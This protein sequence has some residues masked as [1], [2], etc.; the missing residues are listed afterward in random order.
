MLFPMALITVCCS[1]ALCFISTEDGHGTSEQG[2]HGNDVLLKQHAT[3]ILFVQDP[4]LRHKPRLVTGEELPA[5]I[6][7]D[8]DEVCV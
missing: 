2:G 4:E 8:D 5:W 7:R 6:L 1:I 3:D